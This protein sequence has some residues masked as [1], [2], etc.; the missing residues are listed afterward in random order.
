MARSADSVSLTTPIT[1][2]A[3]VV[4]TRPSTTWR[5]KSLRV[6][7]RLDAAAVAGLIVVAIFVVAAA[8]APTIEPRDPLAQNIALRLKAPG[9]LDPANGARYWLGTDG[10]GRDILSRLIEGARVSLMV[11]IGGASISA[12]LGTAIGLSAGYFG[13][14]YDA[15]AMR[16]VDVWQAVPFTIMAIAVAVILGPSLQ[17]VIL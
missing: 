7:R 8:F 1:R 3:G 17:N 9:F 16:I 5:L 15:V 14:W 6:V 2:D 11:G 4:L 12:V 10:L 13:G